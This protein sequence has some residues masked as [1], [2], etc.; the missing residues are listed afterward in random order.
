MSMRMIF[1][2]IEPIFVSVSKNDSEHYTISARCQDKEFKESF[3][4]GTDVNE[5][6]NTLENALYLLA[7]FVPNK[8]R[9]FCSSRKIM[10]NVFTSK[11]IDMFDGLIIKKI[12]K[13]VFT[14][15]ISYFDVDEYLA[16]IGIASIDEINEKSALDIDKI[17]NAYKAI[18]TGNSDEIIIEKAYS[19]H[20]T[21]E[22]YKNSMT[23]VEQVK[24]G[25]TDLMQLFA[26]CGNHMLGDN[27]DIDDIK[28]RQFK[29]GHKMTLEVNRETAI[30]DLQEKA[31]LN[32]SKAFITVNKIGSIYQIEINCDGT[33]TSY[34]IDESKTEF[35]P[36]PINGVIPS[37]RVFIGYGSETLKHVNEIVKLTISH[38]EIHELFIEIASTYIDISK[39][40][41]KV[42]IGKDFD[43]MAKLFNIKR[44]KRLCDDLY[45]FDKKI[46]EDVRK[47]IETCTSVCYSYLTPMS[48]EKFDEVYKSFFNTV[49]GQSF[50]Y[51]YNVSPEVAV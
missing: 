18:I 30:S 32:T 6:M 16:N 40:F 34:D 12:C 8:R 5:S 41:A 37:R 19:A 31:I 48:K 33:K 1:N 3:T 4:T 36:W 10:N 21:V 28:E 27:F 26:V 51:F 14:E 20:K 39:P 25:Q 17:K 38:K 7:Q 35:D 23:W 15:L 2:Y 50:K 24:G 13:S 29:I 49:F 43:Y 9:F 44:N 22:D 46:F 42:L 47:S 11:N 45:S